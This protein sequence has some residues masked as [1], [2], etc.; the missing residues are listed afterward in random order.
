MGSRRAKQAWLSA[1]WPLYAG[2]AVQRGSRC[3]VG[4]YS[5]T[6]R[7]P[8]TARSFWQVVCS[9]TER[10]CRATQK[11]FL[12]AP[13]PWISAN[14][15]RA[16]ASPRQHRALPRF[17]NDLYCLLYC[18]LS[19]YLPYLQARLLAWMSCVSSTSPQLPPWPMALS[20]RATRPS[21]CSTWVAA[22]LMCLSW[23]LATVCLRC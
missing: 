16:A 3:I 12:A 13:A 15:L 9:S 14:I 11:P 18:L 4:S 21:W 5:D 10:R 23:R 22:P 8:D 19:L 7:N 2:C 20:A 17:A 1:V 6:A